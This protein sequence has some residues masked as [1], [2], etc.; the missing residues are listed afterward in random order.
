MTSSFKLAALSVLALFLAGVAGTSQASWRSDG[1]RS[2]YERTVRCESRDA[3]VRYC[4]A[5]IRGGVRLI[6]QL[7]DSACVRGRSWGVE[8]DAIWVSRGCRGRFELGADGRYGSNGRYNDRYDD[9]YDNR[10]DPRYSDNRTRVLRCESRDGRYNFC[11]GY[12]YVS[13]ARLQRQFSDA[14]CRFNRSWGYRNGGVWVDDG[15]RAEF[16][17]YY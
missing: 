17:V 8:R 16:L 15:C 6:E 3:R 1:Y 14:N 13:S 5:D 2:S 4:R 11:G 10:R 12:G 9:R 7:S